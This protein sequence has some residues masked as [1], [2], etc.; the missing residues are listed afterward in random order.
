MYYFTDRAELVR[1]VTDVGRGHNAEGQPVPLIE[2]ESPTGGHGG[3]LTPR[4]QKLTVMS[5]G[6]TKREARRLHLNLQGEIADTPPAPLGLYH[7]QLGAATMSP[8]DFMVRV[9]R[10][11]DSKKLENYSWE[12]M[13]DTMGVAIFD[14]NGY[15]RPQNIYRQAINAAC[16]MYDYPREMDAFVPAVTESLL[17][18][19]CEDLLPPRI[20]FDWDTCRVVNWATDTR[21]RASD[22]LDAV[23]EA[24]IQHHYC[25]C[26]Q[27][28]LYE[29]IEPTT[30]ITQNWLCT[31][32]RVVSE[33]GGL[34]VKHH[35]RRYLYK[36]RLVRPKLP[37]VQGITA[38]DLVSVR[39]CSAR[40]NL[41][42]PRFQIMETDRI[43]AIFTRSMHKPAV[44]GQILDSIG[45]MAEYPG[46][47]FWL[48]N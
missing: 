32:E 22:I 37:R 48:E 34:R 10:R 35:R 47:I 4:L 31:C 2:L 33:E 5:I 29:R 40:F 17:R 26:D 1:H 15:V 18:I 27:A 46:K 6:L 8:G 14:P 16:V 38:A 36:P 30:D 45:E 12:F 11:E 28:V 41:T 7:P 39:P 24:Y 25:T 19:K 44:M 3:Y 43:I 13:Y 20:S 42:R 23:P 21:I 9:L